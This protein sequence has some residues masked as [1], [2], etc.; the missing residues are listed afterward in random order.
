MEPVRIPR[1]ERKW[2]RFD[3]G[4]ALAVIL[5]AGLTIVF[6]W[7]AYIEQRTPSPDFHDPIWPLY[8]LGVPGALAAWLGAWAWRA[9]HWLIASLGFFLSLATPVG[10]FVELSGPIAIGLFFVS[11]FRGWR[12]RSRRRSQIPQRPRPVRTIR[13]RF[14]P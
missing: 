5:A 8:A 12:D 4:L 6:A 10:Y 14:T 9:R 1:P 11:L 13:A 7:I 3:L 2:S